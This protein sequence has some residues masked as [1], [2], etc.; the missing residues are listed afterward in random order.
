MC[1]HRLADQPAGLLC[2]RPDTHTPGHGCTYESTSAVDDR[3]TEGG[4]G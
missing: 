1:D 3:H 4:H 2:N